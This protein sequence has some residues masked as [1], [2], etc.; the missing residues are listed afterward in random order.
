MV[1]RP[2][3]HN[4]ARPVPERIPTEDEFRSIKDP[5]ER[6]AAL[7]PAMRQAHVSSIHMR[8]M[9]PLMCDALADV[10]LAQG[11]ETTKSQKRRVAQKAESKQAKES[12]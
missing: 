1:T 9:I 2:S 12:K 5:L 3:A 11:A 7:A 4:V 8:Y 10:L 6:I